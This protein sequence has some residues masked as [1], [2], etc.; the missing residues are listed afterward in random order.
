M[1]ATLTYHDCT[2]AEQ[3]AYQTCLT[4]YLQ[5]SAAY[6]QLS[7]DSTTQRADL[8]EATMKRLTPPY[9]RNLWAAVQVAYYYLK[10]GRTTRRYTQASAR[11][12]ALLHAYAQ[13]RGCTGFVRESF[14]QF[15]AEL[16][17]WPVQADDAATTQTYPVALQQIID[18][19]RRAAPDERLRLLLGYAQSLPALPPELHNARDSMEHVL[20][21]QAPVFLLAQLQDGKVYYHIDVPQDAPTVRG[22]AGLLY[23]GLN[24]ATPAAITAIP[25]D[26]EVQLALQKVL[27]PI[28]LV[29][30]TALASRMKQNARELMTTGV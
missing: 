24:G 27:S 23:Q 14:P 15:P 16:E 6:T 30:L 10:I 22:F 28:R 13:Q 17:P 20:E 29:G 2:S 26:L 19:F 1:S 8:A 25:N 7:T 3:A 11:L 21:C 4:A 18:A 9:H 12:I 5:A